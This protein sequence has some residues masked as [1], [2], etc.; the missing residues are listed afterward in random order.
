M[1]VDNVV[2]SV[3]GHGRGQYVERERDPD[4]PLQATLPDQVTP[5][6]DPIIQCGTRKHPISYHTDMDISNTTYIISN[7]T[8]MEISDSGSAKRKR[9]FRV[10]STGTTGEPFRQLFTTLQS[11]ISSADG[12]FLNHLSQDIRGTNSSAVWR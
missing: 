9:T 2:A 5:R 4:V 1:V 7:D 12:I 6:N 10:F 8:D 11:S 3:A